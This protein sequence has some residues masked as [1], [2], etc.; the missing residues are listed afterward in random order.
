MGDIPLIGKALF[1]S[2]DAITEN[3]NLV[4]ILTPYVIDKSAKLSKLQQELG[5]ISKLQD[6]YDKKVFENIKKK[7]ENIIKEKSQSFLKSNTNDK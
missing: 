3:D 2:T 4:V 1:S 5:E 6:E 7:N